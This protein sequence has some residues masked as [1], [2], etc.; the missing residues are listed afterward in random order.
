MSSETRFWFEVAPRFPLPFLHNLSG[1][2]VV[3]PTGLF[4]QDLHFCTAIAHC[5]WISWTSLG[6]LYRC[7]LSLVVFAT[8]GICNSFCGGLIHRFSLVFLHWTCVAVL[9]FLRSP[10]HWFGFLGGFWI[11]FNF[12]WLCTGRQWNFWIFL[13]LH[14]P[15]VDYNF[16]FCGG[17]HTGIYPFWTWTVLT[18]S[19]ASSSLDFFRFLVSASEP[20]TWKCLLAVAFVDLWTVNVLNLA[21]PDVVHY[22]FH[23]GLGLQQVLHWHIWTSF[24]IGA[25]R[26]HK[27]SDGQKD[28][29]ALVPGWTGTF[30][31]VE[32]C[33]CQSDACN[34]SAIS[35]KD[36]IPKILFSLRESRKRW[37]QKLQ[38]PGNVSLASVFAVANTNIVQ[39]VV[40]PGG[41]QWIPTLSLRWEQPHPEECNGTKSNGRSSPFGSNRN[42][43]SPQDEGSHQDSDPKRVPRDNPKKARAN[44][45]R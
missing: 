42:G 37:T 8:F 13:A 26:L 45:N 16:C 43:S 31:S 25:P 4:R 10:L 36:I 29:L 12:F 14:W 11:Q 18:G 5:C 41:R 17:P 6:T 21:G 22:H 1:Y 19:T 23:S 27:Q 24:S 40:N 2:V 39:S 9:I 30:T 38:H 33:I 28:V 20:I 15:T 35:Y 34:T 7:G 32:Y 44:T 3:I